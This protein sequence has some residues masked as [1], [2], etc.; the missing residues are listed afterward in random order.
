MLMGKDKLQDDL[1]REPWVL[2]TDPQPNDPLLRIGAKTYKP[3]VISYWLSGKE[4]SKNQ[5]S[6]QYHQGS[7]VKESFPSPHTGLL[8]SSYTDG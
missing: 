6:A 7:L 2:H 8:S 3:T 1:S 5:E 4:P